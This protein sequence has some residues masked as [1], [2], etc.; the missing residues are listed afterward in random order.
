[1]HSLLHILQETERF[2]KKY[3]GNNIKLYIKG[4]SPNKSGKSPKFS[5]KYKPLYFKTGS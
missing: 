3:V 1:M 5:Y 2:Y 4:Y